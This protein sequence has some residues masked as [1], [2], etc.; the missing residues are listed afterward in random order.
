MSFL[1]FLALALLMSLAMPLPF[2]L[3]FFVFVFVY[4]LVW[5]LVCLRC[6]FAFRRAGALCLA[7][8]NG[9][10]QEEKGGG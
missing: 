1:L 8:E 3:S 5:L 6:R 4:L 10:V 2:L 7:S 9:Q